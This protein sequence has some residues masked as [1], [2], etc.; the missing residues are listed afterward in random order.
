MSDS[1]EIKFQCC[2]CGKTLESDD[3]AF[4]LHATKGFFAVPGEPSQ[5]FWCHGE[6]IKQELHS[7]VPFEPEVWSL[8]DSNDPNDKAM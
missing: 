1:N 4:Q 7:S 3:E 8:P 6:C 5:S 2:F